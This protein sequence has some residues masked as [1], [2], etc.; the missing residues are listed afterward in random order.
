MRSFLLYLGLL[1]PGKIM[2]APSTGCPC[3]PKPVDLGYARHQVTHQNLTNAGHRV[4]VYK[5]IRFAEPAQRFRRP[6]FPPAPDEPGVVRSGNY[7]QDTRC[8]SAVPQGAEVLF[9][10]LNGT[11]FGREDCLFLDVYVPGD[12]ACHLSA[13]ATSHGAGVPVLHWLHGSAYAFGSKELG[14]T[15]LGLFDELLS[16]GKPF[17]LVVSNYRMGLYGWASSP[18]EAE[19]QANAGL[20]DGLAAL[21]WSQRYIRHFGGDP[22]RL[23]A[24]GQSTGAA[25]VELLSASPEGADLPFQQAFMSSPALPLKRNV[26]ERRQEVFE[27][28][29]SAANCSSLADLRDMSEEALCEVNR[30]LINDTPSLGGGG[31]LGPGIGFG[32]IVD[33]ELVPELP[34]ANLR[35]HKSLGRLGGMIVAN[36]ANEVSD[37]CFTG[38]LCSRGLIHFTGCHHL[39]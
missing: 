10:G 8:V 37:F 23:T 9:P 39:L 28:I 22:D 21:R 11:V 34:T 35:L 26:T 2:A 6:V 16:Q 1:S 32:P 36:M 7:S 15:P 31:N 13:A 14:F 12:L 33:D 38:S 20:Y 29:L 17:V 19:T 30:R 25:I 5:N 18:S 24:G 3:D 27:S 4:N